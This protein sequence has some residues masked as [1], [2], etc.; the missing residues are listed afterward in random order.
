[1]SEK[2]REIAIFHLC[3]S[4]VDL[5]GEEQAIA[6]LTL[7]YKRHPEMFRDEKE[8]QEVIEKVVSEPEIIVDATHSN[9]DKG[10]YKAAKRLDDKKMGDIVIK[11]D[12]GVNEIFHA[13][14][15]NI[16]EFERLQKQVE[17][18]S[19]VAQFLHPDLQSAWAGSKEH[20]PAQRYYST[21]YK[22]R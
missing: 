19:R 15:K 6:D 2:E 17:A 21:I 22:K 12:R 7:L 20:L 13:N 16:K 8:V 5:L 14:K 4:L 11:N 9:K 10:I 1:M 3:K 18:G